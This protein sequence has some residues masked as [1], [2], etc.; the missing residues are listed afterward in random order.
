MCKSVSEMITVSDLPAVNAILNGL[1]GILL[2]TG[3]L[4]IRRRRVDRHRAAMISALTVS[5]LF[6][7]TYLFYHYHAGS[8]RFTGQGW[9]RPL[10][11]AILI[12]HT[13][14]AAAIVPLVLVTLY[15]ALRGDFVRHRRIARF[16]FPVWLYVSVTGIVV[17]LMLYQLFPSA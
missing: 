12:S 4:S 5:T 11:F 16:T 14:L 9:V 6:L 17:Y 1:A 13:V 8:T 7:A 15:R 10:Y 2:I 3:F